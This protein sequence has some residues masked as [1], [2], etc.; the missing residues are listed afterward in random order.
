MK[1]RATFSSELILR[2]F[3]LVNDIELFSACRKQDIKINAVKIN[4][5]FIIVMSL[6]SMRPNGF[7]LNTRLEFETLSTEMLV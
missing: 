2:L 5:I 7:K 3:A 4:N 1:V 6:S